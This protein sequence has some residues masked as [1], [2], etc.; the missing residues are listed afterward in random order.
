MSHPLRRS[1]RRALSL[2][3]GVALTARFGLSEGLKLILVVAGEWKQKRKSEVVLQLNPLW[4]IVAVAQNRVIGNDNKLLWRIRSDLQRFKALT[5]GKPMVMG[6]KTFQSIGKAL[7]GRETIVVTRDKGFSAA[8]VHVAH[9][10]ADALV[11]ANTLAVKMNA[12]AIAIVGGGEIYAQT[13]DRAA[14]VYVTEVALA[15]E[16]DT[17][18]P[19][20]TPEWNIERREVHPAGVHD[21]AAFAYIDYV[22]V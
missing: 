7:P 2:K 12:E 6:R 18:F 5:L 3:T 16:G 9:D 1:C 14:R 15:P 4:I 21:E 19:A 20:L 17:R 10:L 22:R 8:G 13:L 11:L